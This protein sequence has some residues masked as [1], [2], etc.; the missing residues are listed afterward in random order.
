MAPRLVTRPSQNGMN[1][2]SPLPPAKVTYAPRLARAEARGLSLRRLDWAAVR[3]RRLRRHHLLGR[4]PASALVEAVR[5]SCA[6]HAQVQTA[7]EL[8]IA[9]RVDG[10]RR[11]DVGEGLW[12]QRRLLRM[13]TIRGTIHIQPA[14]DAPVWSTASWAGHAAAAE[15]RRLAYLGL[16]R[17]QMDSLVAGI[18]EALDGQQ[19]TLKELGDALAESL[20]DWVRGGDSN[21]FGGSWPYWRS[22]VYRAAW[23]G[24]V[25]FGP[26]RG[27][28]VTYV[29][30]DRWLG[31]WPRVDRDAALAQ[32]LRW[33]ALAFG[34]VTR[35]DFARWL[36][37][38]PATARHA[39][40]LLGDELEEVELEGERRFVLAGDHAEGDDDP[41]SVRLLPHFDQY[42]LGSHP[43]RL[44]FE[45]W[46]ARGLAVGGGGNV[47]VLAVDGLAAGLWRRL[48]RGRR[49]EIVV[50]SFAPLGAAQL[51]EL[52]AEV[53]RIERFTG[54]E[55]VL[56]MGEVEHRPHM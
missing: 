10:I 30:P 7:A 27:R 53:G 41:T 34:P 39:F 40:Q 15:E 20:G 14:E 54:I 25:C 48:S 55:T 19:L 12:Q 52:R 5:A 37:S 51:R 46:T 13:A 1:P 47:P 49:A 32:T 31:S 3:A 24:L 6:I 38:V 56:T 50:Q 35:Q 36:A 11:A 4:A 18:A 23:A 21:A 29:R 42:L 2:V 8:A 28:E 44:L 26:D 16:T 33:F 17:E 45:A 9:M 43:R 22:A